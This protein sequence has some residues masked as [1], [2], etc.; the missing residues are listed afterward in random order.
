M[1]WNE[2]NECM[3]RDEMRDLQNKRLRTTVERVYHNSTFY[4]AKMQEL[5]VTPMDIENID[6]IVKLPFTT[7]TDLRDQYPFGLFSS[8]MSEIVRLH[9]SSGTTGKPIVAGYTRKD[10]GTW[11]EVMA[12]TFASGGCSRNDIF[13]ISYGYGLFTGGLGAHYGAEMLGA[14]VI[15]ISSGNTEKQIQLMTDFGSTALCCTPSYA[16]YL[17]EAIQEMG[18]RD[19][20][21]LKVG[22][23]GAEP[24]TEEMR[25]EIEQKLRIKAFDIFGLTEVIGPG[26]ACECEAQHGMHVQED[27]FL[28]EI[29]DPKTFKPLQAGEVGELVFTTIT[30]EGMPVLRYRT[31]DLSS[32]FY[33]ECQCGRKTVRMNKIMGRS[34]DMLIIRGV[35]VFPTQIESVLLE[36]NETAP[37][38]HLYVDRVNNTDTFDIHVEMRPENFTDDMTSMLELKKRIEARIQSVVGIHAHIKLVEPRS[39]ERSTGKAKRVTDKRKLY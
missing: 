24:W 31:K 13:Q 25:R 29:I 16:L 14:S 36:F 26:V 15:P 11:S 8:P 7:K 35:N 10:L 9:A 23:F 2:S 18:V 27:N 21:K 17:A 39:I 6:D 32:L 37:H 33:D 34:D 3:S 4:R 22:F 30:K 28:P 38:Y 1:I 20:L 19:K 12:R 5:G